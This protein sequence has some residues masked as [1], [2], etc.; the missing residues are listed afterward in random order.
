MPTVVRQRGVIEEA[1]RNHPVHLKVLEMVGDALEESLADVCVVLGR[2]RLSVMH[3]CTA[4]RPATVSGAWPVVLVVGVTHGEFIVKRVIDSEKPRPDVD[5]VIVVRTPAEAVGLQLI[6][7]ERRD[8]GNRKGRQRTTQR[9]VGRNDVRLAGNWEARG[10]IESIAITNRYA[11]D[12]PR[13][14][15]VKDFT[16][17]DGP[18]QRI[19]PCDFRG[20]QKPSPA[21]V[22]RPLS[23]GRKSVDEAGVDRA[24]VVQTVYI[25]EPERFAAPSKLGNRPTDRSS[26]VILGQ[27]EA[28]TQ[29]EV[30]RVQFIGGQEIVYVA[31][32]PISAGFR[33]VGDKTTTGVP[34]LC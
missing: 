13:S 34:I 32:Q 9:V 1:R 5:L 18:A 7:V 21:E 33:G 22:A 2:I 11:T 15:R 16:L 29:K 8:V 28:L 6:A 10:G 14:G 31:V 23:R 26:P 20:V 3:C 12:Q 19:M 24:V 17:V 25:D 30:R 27:G 4:L